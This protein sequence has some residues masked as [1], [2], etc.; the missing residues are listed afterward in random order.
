MNRDRLCN[1]LVAIIVVLTGYSVVADEPDRK[2]IT[3]TMPLDTYIEA[4]EGARLE[5]ALDTAEALEPEP[6]PDPSWKD[7]FRETPPARKPALPTM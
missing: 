2:V 6:C 3:I 1:A 5:A 4:I 7:L